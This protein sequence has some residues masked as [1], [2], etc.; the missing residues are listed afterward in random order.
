MQ[1]KWFFLILPLLFWGCLEK[2]KLGKSSDSWLPGWDTTL[3]VPSQIPD[4]GSLLLDSVF[5]VFAKMEKTD[6]M[7]KASKELVYPKNPEDTLRIH[8]LFDSGFVF[9]QNPD[10]IRPFAFDHVYR[11]DTLFRK[12]YGNGLF[13]QE[14]PCVTSWILSE[15]FPHPAKWMREGLHQ[16]EIVTNLGTPWSIHPQEIIY[17]WVSHE[18][19]KSS[20]EIEYK[21]AMRFYFEKDSLFAVL[22]QKPKPCL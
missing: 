20:L 4:S 7:I 12:S 17:R 14:H 15:Q 13:V 8:H 5:E 16:A 6:S 9:P 19:P 21:E 2:D 18:K 1:W 11:E 10:F 22:L 3:S